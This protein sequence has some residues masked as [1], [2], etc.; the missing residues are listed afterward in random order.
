MNERLPSKH[1]VLLGLGHTNAHIVRMWGMHP[2]PDADLTCVSNY[3]I[4]TYSGRL[5]AVLAHQVARSEMEIDLVRLC[6]SVG[7][8][9]IQ[10]DPIALDR[11]AR[12]LI[13][14]DRPPIPYSALSIGVGST[15]TMNGTVV[16]GKDMTRQRVE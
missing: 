4:A 6:N 2:I 13:F 1:V 9:L 15:P 14:P 8:R 12:R 16:E 3:P 11:T 7:A 5:P 10:G